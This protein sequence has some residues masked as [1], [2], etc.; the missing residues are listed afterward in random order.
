MK[1]RFLATLLNSE[2][3]FSDIINFRRDGFAYVDFISD[4]TFS[5]RGF[6]ANFVYLPCIPA[7]SALKS[8]PIIEKPPEQKIQPL[9]YPP[10]IREPPYPPATY[11]SIKNNDDFD[12]KY[13]CP[14]A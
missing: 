11:P 4:K 10:A 8:E 2:F 9:P 5:G 14:D 12:R 3:N 1:K 7:Y 6:R 13:H